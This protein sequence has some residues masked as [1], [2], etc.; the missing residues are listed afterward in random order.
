MEVRH[1][2]VAVFY[3]PLGLP[4]LAGEYPGRGRKIGVLMS[5]DIVGVFRTFPQNESPKTCGTFI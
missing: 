4:L 3:T 2:F 5:S 1:I